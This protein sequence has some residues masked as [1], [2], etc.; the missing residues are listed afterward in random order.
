MI[1]TIAKLLFIFSISFI[2]LCL[3]LKRRPVFDH[4]YGFFGNSIN[5]VIGKHR[6][7]LPDVDPNKKIK[8]LLSRIKSWTSNTKEEIQ[9][10]TRT[11]L[12][13]SAIKDY[14]RNESEDEE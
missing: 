4:L 12:S 9:E 1:W 14:M 13:S 5:E 8:P 10:V 6:S 7:P 3:P 2:I 11:G